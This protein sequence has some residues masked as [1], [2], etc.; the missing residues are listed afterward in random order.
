MR[1]WLLEHN[2]IGENAKPYGVGYRIP[3]QGMSSMFAMQVVDILPEQAGDLIIVPREFTAQTGSD[4]DVDK[5]FIASIAYGADGKII[6]DEES[7]YYDE[8]KAIANE[9]LL[10]YIDLITDIKNYSNARGSI[11]VITRMLKEQLVDPVL[12]KNTGEYTPGMS[13]HT[14]SF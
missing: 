4:Y 13:P 11:D 14:L 6:A 5:L 12:K 9:L 2:I 10:N 1:N 3:T 7:D 8:E